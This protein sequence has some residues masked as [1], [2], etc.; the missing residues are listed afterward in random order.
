M[1]KEIEGFYG[2]AYILF[3]ADCGEEVTVGQ[4]IRPDESKPNDWCFRGAYFDDSHGWV[5]QLK[6]LKIVEKFLILHR[7]HEIRLIPDAL[8]LGRDVHDNYTLDTIGNDKMSDVLDRPVVPEPDPYQE[9]A[10]ADEELILR[11]RR[12][13]KPFVDD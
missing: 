12:G 11:L 13:L 2:Y 6:L 1:V 10:E 3:C 8:Y 4:L 5:D 7:I 9:A